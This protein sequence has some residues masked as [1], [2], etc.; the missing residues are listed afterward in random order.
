M[1]LGQVELRVNI[2][3]LFGSWLGAAAF[4]DTGDVTIGTVDLPQCVQYKK[5]RG[6]GR[7]NSMHV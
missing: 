2:V 7:P 4:M 3:Q 5:A 6:T 1:F